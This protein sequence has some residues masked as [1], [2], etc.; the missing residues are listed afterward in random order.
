[1]PDRQILFVP[2]NR[3]TRRV[4]DFFELQKSDRTNFRHVY[5]TVRS[6][7]PRTEHDILITTTDAKLPMMEVIPY[8]GTY[9]VPDEDEEGTSTSGLPQDDEW[10]MLH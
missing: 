6:M 7:Y 10:E 2:V 9:L 5:E 1:M 4:G 8:V 3:E